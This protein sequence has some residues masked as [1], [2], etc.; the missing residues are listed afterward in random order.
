M[1]YLD[2]EIRPMEDRDLPQVL[3]IENLCIQHPYQEKDFLYEL[4]DNP[5]SNLFVIEYSNESLGLKAIV[6][7]IDY[8]VTFDSGTIVQIAVHPDIQ[9]SGVGSELINEMKKDAFA[10]RVRTM[11]L[12]VRA[13][14]EKAINFYK[15]HGFKVSHIKP[16]YYNDNGEDAIYMILEVNING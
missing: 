12:E 3:N 15:K 13:S 11:T 16:G 14:N 5:V 6:G 7:F 9:R 2:M 4:H 10:K 8:W 1:K